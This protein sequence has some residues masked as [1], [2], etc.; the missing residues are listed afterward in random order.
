GAHD[1]IAVIGKNGKGKTTLLKV[2]AGDL[3]PGNGE[4]H[5]HPQTAV[6][7]F[8]QTKIG[9]LSEQCTVE[10]EIMNACGDRQRA[11]DVAGAMLFEGDDALKQIRI[12]SG[13]E[14][15][16]V[17]LGT[18]LASDTNLLLLDEPTNHLDMESCDALMAAIDEFPGA[19]IFVTHNELFLHSLANRFIVFQGERPALFEGTYRDFLGR[20][21]WIEEAGAAQPPP[22]AMNKKLSR[23]AR[24]EIQQRRW[25]ELKP[26]EERI[27]ELEAAIGALE[28][29]ISRHNEEMIRLSTAGSGTAIG[30]L[31]RE[32]HG[33]RKRADTLYDELD[34]ATRDY[35]ERVA[36]FDEEL[37][38]LER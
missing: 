26:V 34:A 27:A 25:N 29:E 33:L 3:A 9:R 4:F 14:R 6:S 30:T 36:R 16:R 19:V 10:E 31:S 37:N 20:V 1:R 38:G 18:I 5:V 22:E 23:K 24:A 32:L 12:L 7:F 21:G 28:R 11:R 35:E 15:S 2:I 13:G 8:D 17:L